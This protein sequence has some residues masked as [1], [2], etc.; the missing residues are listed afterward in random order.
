MRTLSAGSA[1]S[2]SNEISFILFHYGVVIR[3]DKEMAL[4]LSEDCEKS[5]NLVIKV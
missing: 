2:T 1:D 5:A 3:I 4:A